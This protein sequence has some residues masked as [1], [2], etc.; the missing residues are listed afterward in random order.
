M[1]MKK[2]ISLILAIVML[3]AVSVCLI[4]CGKTGE[5]EICGD[6][7]RLK[8]VEFYGETGWVCSDCAEG[9]EEL[10]EG[11]EDLEDYLG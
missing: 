6:E 4:S 10:E 3:L 1:T 7:A 11:L 5:C 2:T 9:L 8:K